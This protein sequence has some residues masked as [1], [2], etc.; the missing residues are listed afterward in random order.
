MRNQRTVHPTESLRAV[1]IEARKH[2]CIVQI[3]S[4][5]HQAIIRPRLMRGMKPINQVFYKAAA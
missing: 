2:G 1:A 5:N 4:I 3:D